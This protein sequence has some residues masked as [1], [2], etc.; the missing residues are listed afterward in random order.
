[1]KT[2]SLL[3][4]LVVLLLLSWVPLPRQPTVL[5]APCPSD[6]ST[7]VRS[8]I[9]KKW[10]PILQKYGLQLPIECPFHPLRDIFWPRQ[11]SKIRHR[12]SQWSCGLCGKSFYNDR[13]L[14]HHF[15]TRH[16]THVNT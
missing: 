13:F 8:I 2:K 12:P 11:A 5:R 10:M 9:H 1:M 3:S 6:R 4:E 14:E 7:L 16:P 15:E